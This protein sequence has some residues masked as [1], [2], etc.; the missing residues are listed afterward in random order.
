MSAWRSGAGIILL[1]LSP[2][3]GT[4]AADVAVA[5]PAELR[6]AVAAARP[7]A[8]LLLAG[9]DYGGGYRFADVRGE[10]GRP[11]VIAAA[12]PKNPPVFRGGNVA[13]HLSNP[14]DVELH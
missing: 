4:V 6:A 10:P 7:G 1:A 3:V 8:R 11:I 5:G 12:D 9:G 13:I 14:A 2:A